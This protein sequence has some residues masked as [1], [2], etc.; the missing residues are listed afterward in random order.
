[1]RHNSLRDL[2]AELLRASACKDVQIEPLLLKTKGA[3]LPSGSST[4]DNARLDVS[5][6]SIWNPLEKAFLDIRVFHAQAPSNRSHGTIKKM[7]KSHEQEKKR[8]YNQRVLQI[9]HATFTPVVFSTTG[10]MGVEAKSL[11]KRI[12]ERTSTKSGQTYADTMK[13]LRTRL[14]FDLLRTTIIALD[15]ATKFHFR[16]FC[17][18]IYDN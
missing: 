12:A 14:R 17:N 9:E 6:R 8:K 11:I 5:A 1:M 16:A 10:G 18:V 7:Y 2:F 4:E 13:F 15:A 3:Q